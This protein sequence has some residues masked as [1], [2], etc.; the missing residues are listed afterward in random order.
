MIMLLDM[1]L[2]FA[3]F[4]LEVE[5]YIDLGPRETDWITSLAWQ[6]D[7]APDPPPESGQGRI[8]HPDGSSV[9][10]SHRTFKQLRGNHATSRFAIALCDSH[11]KHLSEN[12][13]SMRSTATLFN[14]A[15]L[16]LTLLAA[17]YPAVFTLEQFHERSQPPSN[18]HTSSRSTVASKTISYRTTR[19]KPSSHK[20]IST[21]SLERILP[22]QSELCQRLAA[23][24]D[25]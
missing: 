8:G 10:C 12:L 3:P 2:E 13:S 6:L 20:F 19:R 24:K 16:Q 23:S 21:S 7:I 25:A 14:L 11:C 9:G 5:V 22:V 17:T 18:N 1:L 15:L 4:L